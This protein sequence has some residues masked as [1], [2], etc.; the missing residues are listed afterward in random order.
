DGASVTLVSPVEEILTWTRL[1][2]Q[3]WP[4][5][6]DSQPY[7]VAEF[8]SQTLKSVFEEAIAAMGTA[9]E[10]ATLFANTYTGS[11]T[12]TARPETHERLA[13][14]A[15]ELRDLPTSARLSTARI[16]VHRRIATSLAE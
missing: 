15:Q 8:D 4:T 12:V 9:G 7:F 10:G 5:T 11:V 14:L 13:A 3:A 6:L 1:A 16:L 2:E